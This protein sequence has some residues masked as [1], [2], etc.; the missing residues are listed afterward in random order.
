MTT[1]AGQWA[2]VKTSAKSAF[3][4]SSVNPQD[5]RW[6]KL[7]GTSLLPRLPVKAQPRLISGDVNADAILYIIDE[8]YIPIYVTN[9]FW[10]TH[11]REIRQEKAQIIETFGEAAYYFFGERTKIYNFAGTLLETKSLSKSFKTQ[12]YWASSLI[13]LYNRH[14]RGTM[15]AENKHEAVLSY[16]NNYIYGYVTNLNTD[17]ASNTP[18]VVSFTFSMIVREHALIDRSNLKDMYNY[19]YNITDPTKKKEIAELM[20]EYKESFDCVKELTEDFITALRQ[21]F[22]D[23]GEAF[24]NNKTLNLEGKIRVFAV[25]RKTDFLEW[26]AGKKDRLR[27]FAK[28]PTKVNQGFAEAGETLVANAVKEFQEK[29]EKLMGKLSNG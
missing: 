21:Y 29:K 4:I 25:F 12:Y 7:T 14:L 27:K 15:L 22:N 9:K 28:D 17:Y 26:L 24:L 8:N 10:L 13:D 16:K 3:D 6:R 1:L 11:A 23:N 20:E 19:L 5:A 2:A 18:Q